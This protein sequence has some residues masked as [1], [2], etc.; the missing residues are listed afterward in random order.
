MKFDMDKIYSGYLVEFR[1]GTIMMTMRVNQEDSTKIF[2]DGVEWYYADM[3]DENGK[4]IAY[5]TSLASTLFN[6]EPQRKRNLDIM[7]VYGL[8][9]RPSVY[10]NAMTLSTMDRPLVWERNDKPVIITIGQIREKFG[11]E[12][13]VRIKIK[14]G[15][16]Q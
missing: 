14:V 11:I 12:D 15:E 4:S 13:D 1:D 5:D 10:N 16:D 3:W 2:T 8:V 9:S 7:K 6:L